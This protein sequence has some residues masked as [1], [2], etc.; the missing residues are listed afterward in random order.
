MFPFKVSLQPSSLITSQSQVQPKLPSLELKINYKS[1]LEVSLSVSSHP[2]TI[3]KVIKMMDRNQVPTSSDLLIVQSMPVESI[4]SSITTI[5]LKET[6]LLSSFMKEIKLTL[7]F[8]SAKL[9]MKSIL[10][11]L[12]LKLSLI[13]LV[14]KM[15]KG[16]KL[17]YLLVILFPTIRHSTLTPMD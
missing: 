15:N 5:M 12:K 16:R 13:K 7:R 4:Q 14:F 8:I 6:Q 2:T 11:D 9:P 1:Q 3:I 10:K 17:S